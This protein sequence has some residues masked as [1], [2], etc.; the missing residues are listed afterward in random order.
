MQEYHHQHLTG[1][2]AL[3]KKEN[4][5]IEDCLFDDGESPLKEGRN[6]IVKG[7]T[8]GWKYPL[9]YGKGHHVSH[10]QWLEMARSGVWYT[11]DSVFEDCDIIAS[12]NFRKN[13]NI[14]LRNITFHHGQE[15]LW[16]CEGVKLEHVKALEAPYFGMKSKDLTIEDLY[17]EGDYFFDGGENL[18]IKNSILHSKDA[19][20]NCKHVYL[21]NCE[22]D[23]EYFGWNSEDVTLVRCTIRSHQGFC[24]MKNVK[25]I[26]CIVLDTDLA[27]EYCSEIE[28]TILSEFESIKNPIN[29]HIRVNGVKEV[30]RDD[31]AIDHQKTKIE[32]LKEDGSYHEI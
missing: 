29:G 19:C 22:I 1:E 30:I 4:A 31:P 8:F 3:F 7:S 12:K 14:T 25:L 6:L 13:H 28:A 15:T 18:K 26:D 24:Y 2:R 17:L 9:W 16:W 27:F 5:T 32:A 21:E 10:C 20:W 23:G 11:D